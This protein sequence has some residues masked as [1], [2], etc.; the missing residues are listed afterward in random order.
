METLSSNI[1]QSLRLRGL[2]KGSEA[3]EERIAGDSL[4]IIQ[5]HKSQ[6]INLALLLL[7]KMVLWYNKFIFRMEEETNAEKR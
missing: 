3:F 6:F 7:G 5:F 1:S 2:V 4:L